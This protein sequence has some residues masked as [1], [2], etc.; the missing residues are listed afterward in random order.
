LGFDMIRKSASVALAALC[1]L[2]AGACTPTVSYNGF[3][4]RE[5]KPQDIK[6]G[7]DTRSTV[8]TKLGSPSTVATFEPNIWFYVSQTT[9]QQAYL[10]PKL[11]DRDVVAIAFDKDEKVTSV[12]AYKLKDGFKV[13]YSDRKTPTRGRELSVLEQILGNVGRGGMLPQDQN[14]PGNPRGGGGGR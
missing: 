9:A 10:R 5:D 3:Q 14:D 8:L 7:V 11:R 1:L 2:G 12:N 13:A 6:V 4:A